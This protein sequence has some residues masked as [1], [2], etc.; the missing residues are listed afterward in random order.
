[1]KTSKLTF[2][3]GLV[4]AFAG[5]VFAFAASAFS[6]AVVV[7]DPT[8]EPRESKLTAADRAVFDT[9]TAAAK[10]QIST[11][12]CDPEIDVAGFASGAFTRSGATQT[13]VFYQYCQTGNGFGW[14]GLVLIEG[15]KVVGNY[16]AEAGWT[17]DIERIQDIN[18]NGLDEF[19][20]AYSGG[21]HQG[22]GGTGVD[23]MEFAGGLPKGVG[24]YK[25]SEYGPTEASSA[26]KLTAKPGTTPS[27]FKQKYFSGEGS[28]YKK[29]GANA[30]AK[31]GKAMSKFSAVK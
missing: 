24:W 19:T 2:A 13:I 23:L 25:A 27:F 1:M 17:V 30:P 15:G 4:F 31:L 10:R 6:Q 14:V 20:L 16:L 26:W 29:V 21:M 5:L 28:D 12:T 3:V 8:K 9:A 7:H 22:M 11:D 18:K